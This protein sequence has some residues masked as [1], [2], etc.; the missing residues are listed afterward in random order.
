MGRQCEYPDSAGIIFQQ[1]RSPATPD[2]P[3]ASAKPATTRRVRPLLSHALDATGSYRDP[4]VSGASIT[5]W[6]TVQG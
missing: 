4:D 5:E 1:S 3:L 2:L 6:Q